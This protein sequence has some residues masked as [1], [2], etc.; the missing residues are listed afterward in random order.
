MQIPTCSKEELQV[1]DRILD[2]VLST[3]RFSEALL[4]LAPLRRLWQELVDTSK[5]SPAGGTAD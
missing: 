4:R 1:S 5:L 3:W 2:R